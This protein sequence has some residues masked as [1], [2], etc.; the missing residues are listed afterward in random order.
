[1]YSKCDWVQSM[2]FILSGIHTGNSQY[3]FVVVLIRSTFGPWELFCL[4]NKLL[5]LLLRLIL[6]VCNLFTHECNLQK[7]AGSCT[8]S[9]APL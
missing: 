6:G 4:H 7:L 2:L 5:H 1:M 9:L 3:S 8:S